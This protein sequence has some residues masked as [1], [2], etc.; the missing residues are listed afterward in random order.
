MT[1][2][3][4]DGRDDGEFVRVGGL[5]GFLGGQVTDVVV[6]EIDVDERAQLAVAGVKI[7]AQLGVGADQ[8]FEGFGNSGSRDADRLLS[9][10]V[11]AQRS[12]NVDVHDCSLLKF[13]KACS[14]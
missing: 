1:A 10:G 11:G 5:G 7:L 14:C 12:G 2:P 9:A 6:I 8:L 13:K 3:A 4:G